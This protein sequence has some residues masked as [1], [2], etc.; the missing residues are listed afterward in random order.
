M[1]V[2]I[3]ESLGGFGVGWLARDEEVERGFEIGA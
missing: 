2:L 3:V 1:D